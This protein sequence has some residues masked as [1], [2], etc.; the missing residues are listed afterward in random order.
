M[1]TVPVQTEA[2]HL[3]GP[4][5]RGSG[6]LREFIAEGG[7]DTWYF[8]DATLRRAFELMDEYSDHPMDLADASLV[9]AAEESRATT[10]LAL[11][12]GDFSSYRARIGRGHRAFKRIDPA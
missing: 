1:S 2:F 3:L 11:D 7:L 6:A 4:A 10:I 12:R 5:S 8:S 9:T